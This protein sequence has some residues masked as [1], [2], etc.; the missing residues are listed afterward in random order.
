MEDLE[1]IRKTAKT[2]KKNK[3]WI[4][5]L[6]TWSYYQLQQMIVYKAKMLG[7]PT[8]FVNPAYT[9][10][11]CS[12]CGFLGNRNKKKFK[13]PYCGH[14]SHADVNAAFNISIWEVEGISPKDTIGDSVSSYN[15]ME[16][17]QLCE[18]EDSYKGSSDEPQVAMLFDRVTTNPV[19]APS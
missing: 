4:Y 2:N 9:S 17:P 15:C 14:T 8:V 1:S 5:S 19:P 3:D 12:K 7:V 18:E 10:K 11:T 6:N 13:C 16:N